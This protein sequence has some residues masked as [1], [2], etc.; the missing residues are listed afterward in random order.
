ML[1]LPQPGFRYL[2]YLDVFHH[3]GV[4]EVVVSPI[5]FHDPPARSSLPV[6]MI[7]EPVTLDVFVSIRRCNHGSVQLEAE[8]NPWLLWVPLANEPIGKEEGYC[9]GL[10]D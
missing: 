10:G 7:L 2:G 4:E 1:F 6:P 8:I 3:Q 5:T 9:T